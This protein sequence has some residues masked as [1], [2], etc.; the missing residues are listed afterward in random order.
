[1]I[2][3]MTEVWSLFDEYYISTA[4]S[5]IWTQLLFP[6]VF[7]PKVLLVGLEEEEEYFRS[8]M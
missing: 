7:P 5:Q 2:I 4:T 8:K 1:M 6:V 3:R